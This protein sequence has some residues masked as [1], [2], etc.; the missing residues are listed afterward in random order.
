MKFAYGAVSLKGKPHAMTRL[1]QDLRRY[2][3]GMKH[4]TRHSSCIASMV[5]GKIEKRHEFLFG[6]SVTE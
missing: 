2:F 1:K 3:H 4:V 5:G 6:T